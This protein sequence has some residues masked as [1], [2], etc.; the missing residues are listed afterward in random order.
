[1][2]NVVRIKEVA[3]EPSDDG[4]ATVNIPFGLH[5]LTRFNL[6]DRGAIITA[7][8]RAYAEKN[9]TPDQV[10]LRMLFTGGAS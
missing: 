6:K 10:V 3:A 8:M 2:E 1:M 5:A 9:P 7:V 4:F